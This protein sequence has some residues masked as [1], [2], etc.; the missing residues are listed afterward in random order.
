MIGLN[1]ERLDAALRQSSMTVK[2]SI[3][4]HGTAAF[5]GGERKQKEG[6]RSMGGNENKKNGSVQWGGT[7]T[8]RTTVRLQAVA[9]LASCRLHNAT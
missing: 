6:Q 7:K 3:S 9:T 2:F 5:N 4:C 8:K 1:I